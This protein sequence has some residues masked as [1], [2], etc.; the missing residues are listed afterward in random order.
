MYLFL[1]IGILAGRWGDFGKRETQRCAQR[2]KT[3][4]VGAAPK[5]FTIRLLRWVSVSLRGHLVEAVALVAYM[6]LC[7]CIGIFPAGGE[8]FGNGGR[9]GAKTTAN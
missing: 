3:R 2:P 8:D 6:Y 9:K 1:R 4:K 5:T 7:L